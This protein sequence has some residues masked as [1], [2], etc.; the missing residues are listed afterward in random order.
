VPTDRDGAASDDDIIAASRDAVTILTSE[1]RYQT[2]FHFVPV[3]LVQFDRTE[4]RRLRYAQ[5]ARCSEFALLHRG[6]SRVCGLRAELDSGNRGE[7]A[8]D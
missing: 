8:R 6:A 4:L 3:A 1:Q 7:P 5:D 2:L